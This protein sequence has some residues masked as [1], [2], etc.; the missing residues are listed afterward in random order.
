MRK[1]PGNIISIIL[2]I[3]TTTAMSQVRSGAAFLKML[4]GA[5]L[6]AMA[7]TATAVIDDPHALYANPAAAAYVRPWVWSAGYTKW[8]ADIYN[9]SF[10]YGRQI[11]TPWSR[12]SGIAF[13]WLY[14]GVPSFDSSGDHAPV[15][16]T[17]DMVT[18]LSLGQPLHF[19]PGNFAAGTSV[20][21]YQSTLAQYVTHS[22]IFDAGLSAR[23]PIVQLGRD[24]SGTMT[25]GGS[26]TQL[27]QELR[28]ERVGTPLPL[29][30]RLG[31]GLYLGNHQSFQILVTADFVKVRDE[32][33]FLS[34]GTE[35]SASRL[36][37]LQ[38]GY[39]FGN[40]LMK[41]FTI[42]AGI[43]LE[44]VKASLGEAFPGRGNAFRFD[45]AS[46]DNSDLF[47]RTY[48]GT[49]THHQS[50]PSNFE[51]ISPDKNARL[52]EAPVI[53]H[54]QESSDPD[55][56]DQVY[57]VVVM[58]KDSAF[59]ADLVEKGQKDINSFLSKI[60]NQPHLASTITQETQFSV[61]DVSSGTYH[62]VVAAVDSDDHLVYAKINGEIIN[63]FEISQPDLDISSWFIKP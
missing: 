62:W 23:T 25:F 53:L 61:S 37:S 20:K 60:N 46:M 16:S 3:T 55:L 13:G 18:S 36:F 32:E 52:D 57:Y 49:A 58:D 56:F 6:Q 33:S 50:A 26:M 30:W 43:N 39:N 21:Y 9:A 47:S 27:G 35:I 5:R 38:L 34:L 44:D 10:M 22:F 45:L 40:D 7:N 42:G 54:W 2:F 11:T 41:K 1:V 31:T 28:F 24:L 17:G 12:K 19:L 48:R 63:R 15:A 59:M 51:Y 29:T 8:I 4:P 14:Q